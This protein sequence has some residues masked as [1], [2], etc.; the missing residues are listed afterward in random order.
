MQLA[1]AQGSFRQL[2]R[3]VWFPGYSYNATLGS[4]TQL[5]DT[6][7]NGYPVCVDLE[8]TADGF[9]APTD[10]ANAGSY[11]GTPT[12][13]YPTDATYGRQMKMEGYGDD[14]FVINVCKPHTSN[15]HMFAG[16][17]VGLPP[18][19]LLGTAGPEAG[20]Y[21]GGVWLDVQVIGIARAYTKADMDPLTPTTKGFLGCVTAE[22]W[23]VPL[24]S[25]T[26]ANNQLI[27]AR[28]LLDHDTSTTA[29]FS[30]VLV[31]SVIR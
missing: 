30:P 6:I 7:K 18:A 24:A 25:S 21:V 26:A 9:A 27:C 10:N 29:A 1:Q 12:G 16:C 3:R 13:T 17:I 22:W 4:R 31:N 19:G 2:T 11:S 23:L 20:G 5:T 8:A 28:A 15:L 14:R